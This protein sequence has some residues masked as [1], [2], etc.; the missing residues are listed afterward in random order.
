MT[1]TLLAALVAATFAGC[2]VVQPVPPKL[3][4]PPGSSTAAQNELLEHWWT[5]FDDPVL[6]ALIEEA[7]TNNLDLRE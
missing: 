1:R 5:A 3:D 6:T 7:Y 2:A 4:L